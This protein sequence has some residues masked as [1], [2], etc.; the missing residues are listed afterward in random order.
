MTMFRG[1]GNDPLNIVRGQACS[2]SLAMTFVAVANIQDFY[3][4]LY[5]LPPVSSQ[6]VGHD[7]S[8]RG[9]GIYRSYHFLPLFFGIKG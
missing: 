7:K 4:L 9:G 2:G 3:N 1:S 8:T 6:N 5:P